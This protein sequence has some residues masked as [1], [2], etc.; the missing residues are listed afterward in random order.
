[1]LHQVKKITRLGDN[2]CV[3]VRVQQR[4]E[5][6][7]GTLAGA[8]VWCSRSGAEF[9]EPKPFVPAQLVVRH[10]VSHTS[11][12]KALV[13]LSPAEMQSVAP[14][15]ASRVNRGSE[16]MWLQKLCGADKQHAGPPRAGEAAAEQ[17]SVCAKQ[18]PQLNPDK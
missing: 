16:A 6:Y 3:P 4:N 15:E 8:A 11:A 12:C 14:T 13:L 1:M 17:H 2:G 10:T 18:L 7:T 9:A 5:R